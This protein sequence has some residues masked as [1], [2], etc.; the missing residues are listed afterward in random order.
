[1]V[2]GLNP[3]GRTPMT[4]AVVAA[5]QSLRYT[6]EAATVI[7]VSDG[8][9]NCNPDP[10]A[11]ARELEAAGIGFTAHVIG[12]DVAAEPEAR[13]Q[14]QCIAENTGGLFLTADNA[15]ELSSALQ[16]GRAGP[17]G[18]NRDTAGR[19][20]TGQHRAHPPGG[21]DPAVAGW[22]HPV[23]RHPRP[24]DQRAADAG[25]YVARATREEPTGPAAY[26]TAFTVTEGMAAPSSCRCRR[27]STPCPSPLPRG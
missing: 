12:F 19:G 2:N 9:E 7:L 17:R 11:M 21:L 15:A 24:R 10:C 4:D 14:M 5:A 26:Q 18:R 6:E 22:N 16:Q 8:I 27:S 13:A 25:A 1:M 20:H 3:R 23:R